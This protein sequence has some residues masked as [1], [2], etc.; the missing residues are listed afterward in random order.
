MLQGHSYLGQEQP[1]SNPWKKAKTV[2]SNRN[3]KLKQI[4]AGQMCYLLYHN[5][6]SKHSTIHIN[7]VF[8][9]VLLSSSLL[10]F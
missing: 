9:L 4:I 6:I 7:S 5:L 3:L 8:K 2:N 1:S 10:R